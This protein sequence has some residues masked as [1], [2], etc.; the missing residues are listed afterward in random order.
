LGYYTRVG[1]GVIM[2]VPPPPPPP[3]SQ[4]TNE[5]P[6]TATRAIMLKYLT[7]FFIKELLVP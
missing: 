2:V 5:N 7:T 1:G 4:E 6:I 3:V